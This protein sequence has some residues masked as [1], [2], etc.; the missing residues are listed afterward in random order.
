MKLFVE[1]LSKRMTYIAIFIILFFSLD[2]ITTYIGLEYGAPELNP[3][4]ELAQKSP[5]SFLLVKIFGTVILLFC[6]YLL[7]KRYKETK[8]VIKVRNKEG[9]IEEITFYDE[10]KR[11]I[12]IFTWGLI[13]GIMFFTIFVNLLSIMYFLRGG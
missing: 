4:M 11:E 7:F 8:V 1:W 9:K 3:L 12:E 13:I 5:E 2:L 6:F 10:K